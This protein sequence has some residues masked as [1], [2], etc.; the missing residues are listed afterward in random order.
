MTEQPTV[1]VRLTLYTGYTGA[2]HEGATEVP[3]DEWEKMT[4]EER[5]E[6]LRPEMQALIE[7]HIEVGYEVTD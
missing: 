1:I 6:Y 5:D 2:T 4:E 3:R 7:N